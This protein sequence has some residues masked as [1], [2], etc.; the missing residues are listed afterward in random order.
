MLF[1]ESNGSLCIKAWGVMAS[2]SEMQGVLIPTLFL[3]N[4]LKVSGHKEGKILFISNT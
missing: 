4:T 2:N 1:S 3:N